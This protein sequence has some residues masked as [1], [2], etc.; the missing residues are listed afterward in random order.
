MY[1]IFFSFIT[2]LVFLDILVVC[3]KSVNAF[4]IVL[5]NFS[6]KFQDYVSL[7]FGLNL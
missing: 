4:Q 3:F 2:N 7:K 6:A 1:M 5:L